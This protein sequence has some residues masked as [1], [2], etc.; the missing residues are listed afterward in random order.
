MFLDIATE[1]RLLIYEFY[2]DEARRVVKGNQPSNSHYYLLHTCRQLAAEA[3]PILRPYVSL[4]NER[5]I[6]AFISCAGNSISHIRWAD[7]ASD[8]RTSTTRGFETVRSF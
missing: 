8:G 4:R 3:G 1:L 2:F 7:V 6:H 5:Q